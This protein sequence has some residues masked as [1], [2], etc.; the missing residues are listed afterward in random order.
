MTLAEL[1]E[2]LE[3][4]LDEDTEEEY[5]DRSRLAASALLRFINDHNVTVLF[6]RIEDTYG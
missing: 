2:R 3:W 1:V 4:L 6:G 5:E